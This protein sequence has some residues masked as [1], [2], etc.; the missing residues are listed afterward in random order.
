M[1]KALWTPEHNDTM[2]AL[3]ETPLQQF[4]EKTV[5]IAC[6][7]RNGN[8]CIMHVDGHTQAVIHLQCLHDAL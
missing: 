4:A 3:G 1:S 5:D 2:G 6:I 8:S 7:L